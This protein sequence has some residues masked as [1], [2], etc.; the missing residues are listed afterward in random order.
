MMRLAVRPD[1]VWWLAGVSFAE[2]SFLPLPPDPLLL[3]MSL[4]KPE[5]AWWL[6]TVCTV[7]SV[8]GGVLGY[9]IGYALFDVL[10]QP[11]LHAY[12][13][14]AGFAR[15]TE[16]YAKYGL[17]VILLKG[18]TPIP[19]K[20]VTIASGAAKYNFAVFLLA[21][22]ITRGGRFFLIAALLR[23]YGEGARDFVERRLALVL[24]GGLAM[25]VL[26][27]VMLRYI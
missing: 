18:L 1:A 5:R 3:A 7:G 2:S 4:A 20:I 25:L 26:G 9:V 13:Y 10:A 14:E 24:C 21:S 23:R 19:F 17:W 6:A 16:M 22:F 11:L 8:A 27:V 12:G 15:F